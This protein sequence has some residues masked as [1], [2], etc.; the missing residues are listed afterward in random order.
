MKLYQKITILSLALLGLSST[1]HAISDAELMKQGIWR[2]PKTGLMW[3]RCSVGQSW[4]G[5]TC[6][7]TAIQFNWQ[8]AKD[9]VAKFTNEQAKGGYTDWRL[10]TIEELSSIRYC[11]KGWERDIKTKKV[12]E[13]TAQGRIEKEVVVSN[14]VTT[15]IIPTS[16][17][18]TTKVPYR[19]AD[20]SKEPALDTNIFP[21]IPR[22][23]GYGN[24]VYWSSSFDNNGDFSWFMVNMS[25]GWINRADKEYTYFVLAVRSD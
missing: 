9:Y 3:D 1:A 7:G 22:F 16:K 2:D 4:N 24:S 19:C 11:S 10:P 13:L 25:I 5:T 21:N 15:I 17:G 12:S 14:E 20:N 23:E 18:K 8:D 6:T